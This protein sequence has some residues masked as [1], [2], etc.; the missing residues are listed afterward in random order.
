MQPIIKLSSFILPL[1]WFALSGAAATD[2]SIE[3]RWDCQLESPGGPIRFDLELFRSSEVWSGFLVNG[4]ERIKIP[5]VTYRDGVLILDISHYDSEIIARLDDDSREWSGRWKKRR[6]SGWG[7]LEFKARRPS[8]TEAQGDRAPYVGRWSVDFAASDEPAVAIIQADGKHNVLATFLTTTGDYRYL[9]GAGSEDGMTVSCFDGAHAFLFQFGLQ[10]DGSLKGR[11][12]SSNTWYEEWTATRDANAQLPDAF[13]Q[14]SRV[15]G[16]N[17]GNLSF[18]DLNGEPTRLDDARFK[19]KARI[20]Y[21]FGSWCPNCHDAAQ[22]YTFLQ[23]KYG[24]RG[25]SILGL[26]F[27][28]T[29]DFEMYFLQVKRYLE[30]NGVEYPVLLAGLADKKQASKA[31]PLLDRVRSFPT[32]IFLDAQQ[33]VR[34]IHTGFS[35]P[36][37]GREYEELKKRFELLIESILDE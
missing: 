28:M 10:A 3:G 31:L 30:R 21:V 11:F 33:R 9:S 7:T 14:T 23:E 24:D 36:A 32:T 5:A 15:A 26:A 8:E 17:L 27:E 2:D 20:I 6:G 19:G 22:Y 1:L 12:W 34:G 25:L 18:P 37:T 35:G 29:G 4:P 16:G 13:Q